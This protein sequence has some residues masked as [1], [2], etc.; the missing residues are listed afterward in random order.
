MG[1]LPRA[2]LHFMPGTAVHRP[3]RPRGVRSGLTRQRIVTAARSV[4]SECGYDATTFQAVA[5]RAD[6]TR[7]AINHYFANKQLLYR[8]VLEQAESLVGRAV[9]RARTEV[10]LVAQLSAFTLSAAQLDEGDRTAA[11]FVVTAVLDAQRHPE[12]QELV[13]D[14]SASTREFLGWALTAALD[15]GELVTDADVPALTEM[16]LAVLW[17]IGFYVA[18]VGDREESETVIA[19]VESLWAHQLWQLR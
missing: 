16:L 18:F 11:A 12:L 14:V 19:H 3:G 8:A 13:G 10:D 4:F 15:R 2:R 7:P 9:D 1:G 17:G 6:L 5:T